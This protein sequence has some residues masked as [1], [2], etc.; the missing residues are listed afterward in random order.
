MD[1]D[2]EHRASANRIRAEVLSN[3]IELEDSLTEAL[4]YL[5]VP[6]EENFYRDQLI[7]DVLTELTFDK[8]IKLFKKFVDFYPE[9]FSKYPVVKK[10]HE[11]RETRNQLAHRA[12][13]WRSPFEYEALDPNKLDF[14]KVGRNNFEFSLND[15]EVYI[16]ECKFLSFYVYD[17]V[18]QIL[19]IK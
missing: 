11:I 18:S 14:L 16:E 12:T 17:G 3:A 8:K 9:F 6:K 4:G 10:L 13:R 19:N 5:Y 2:H 1:K 15:L 7:S